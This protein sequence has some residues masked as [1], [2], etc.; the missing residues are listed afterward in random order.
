MA[1]TEEQMASNFAPAYAAGNEQ[2]AAD[3]SAWKAV[4]RNMPQAAVEQTRMPG[5]WMP[6]AQNPAGGFGGSGD[7]A[8]GTYGAGRIP[9]QMTFGDPRGQVDPEALRIQSQGGRYDMNARRDAIAARVLA[10]TNAEA[11]YN[12]SRAVQPLAYYGGGIAGDNNYATGA[13]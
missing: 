5:E 13:A 12:Q 11:A 2:S 9:N 1:L 8:Y 10:N 6:P 4:N 7:A 3:L